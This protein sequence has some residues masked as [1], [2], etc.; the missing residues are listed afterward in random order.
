VDP[1]AAKAHPGCVQSTQLDPRA[2]LAPWREQRADLRE[3]AADERDVLADLRDQMADEREAL[4]DLRDQIA[5]EREALAD[6][7]EQTADQQEAQLDA[8]MGAHGLVREGR[9][10]RGQ[11][12]TSRSDARMIRSI[13]M[14][15]RSHAAQRRAEA[16]QQ[17]ARGRAS[18]ERYDVGSQLTRDLRQSRHRQDEAVAQAQALRRRAD[19][20]RR[21]ARYTAEQAASIIEEARLARG[22]AVNRITALA[23][24][25]SSGSQY[26]VGHSN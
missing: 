10:E 6:R 8:L 3:E 9:H 18:R 14:A 11:E 16:S 26:Q 15:E 22:E 23:D 25:I 21:S 19:D 17:R 5:D 20:L 24:V 2:G 7:R 1:A 13:A 12:A 4:A